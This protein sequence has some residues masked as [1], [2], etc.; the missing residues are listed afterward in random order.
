MYKQPEM[1][2]EKVGP[3]AFILVPPSPGASY[4]PAPK[5][6]D[7]APETPGETI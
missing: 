7:V 4:N 5:R 2:V 1:A 3:E 6:L